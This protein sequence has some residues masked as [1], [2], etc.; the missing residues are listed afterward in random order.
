MNEYYK[1]VVGYKSFNDKKLETIIESVS[2]VIYI[3]E[4]P[5]MAL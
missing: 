3:N 4:S 1:N 5:L 2:L